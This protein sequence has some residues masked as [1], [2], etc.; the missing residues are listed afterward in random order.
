MNKV[1]RRKVII[2]VL[3]MTC[4][5]GAMLIT[6]AK[7]VKA[8]SYNMSF[9]RYNFSTGTDV[10]LGYRTR[11]EDINNTGYYSTPVSGNVDYAWRLYLT[12]KQTQ[13]M[14]YVNGVGEVPTSGRLYASYRAKGNAFYYKASHS[15]T[16]N[17]LYIAGIFKTAS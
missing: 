15:H 3:S 12:D 13:A 10:N 5:L 11:A 17:R 7:D 1:V 14:N 2:G 9:L 4:A 8:T 6:S 16:G